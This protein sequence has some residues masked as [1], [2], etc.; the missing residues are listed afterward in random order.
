MSGFSLVLLLGGLAFGQSVPPGLSQVHSVYVLP[1][2][3]GY[4]QFLANHLAKSGLF[5][6]VTDPKLA[7]AVLSEYVGPGFEEKMGELYQPPSPPV[8]PPKAA[9]SAKDAAKP[10]A[11]APKDDESKDNESKEKEEEKTS[12]AQ[13]NR[14]LF[15]PTTSS[16]AR[17]K[18]NVF[19]VDRSSRRVIWSF[20]EKP[21]DLRPQ[22][23]N[24]AAGRVVNR[25]RDAM[26]RK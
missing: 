8:V 21:K 12:E 22:E 9:E 7:D 18:G 11:V 25:L 17:G 16:W 19:L 2:A 3:N 1:M 26:Q 5:E 20:F 13:E 24:K 4:D 10:D 15:R 23:L 14:D 6:V